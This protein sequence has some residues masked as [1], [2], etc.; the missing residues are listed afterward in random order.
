MDQTPPPPVGVAPPVPPQPPP[1]PPHGPPSHSPPPPP[2][3]PGGG[4]RRVGDAQR[5]GERRTRMPGWH[6]GDVVRATF[7]VGLL[8]V[9]AKLLWFSQQLLLTA[10][11]G[12]LFGLA[13]TAAVD[14]M[15]KF[16]IPRGIAAAIV[17]LG[18]L[19]LL[20]GFGAILA[21]TLKTQSREL[22]NRLPE[23][24]DKLDTW[25]AK[26]QGGLLGL[27]LPRGD[28]TTATAAAP[29]APSR[30]GDT[31]A[32]RDT[33]RRQGDTAAAGRA[34]FDSA[35][36]GSVPGPLD[37]AR[38]AGSRLRGQILGQ[39]SGAKRYFFP[40]LTSTL[41]VLG[42]IVLV[43]FLAI[44]VATDPDTYHDG[45][46][47]LFPHRTRTRAG[48]VLT[49]MATALRKWLVTQLIAMLAI[50][51]VTTVALLVLKVKAAVS[52]GI[53]AGLLEFIPTIGPLLSAVPAVAMAFIDSPE[54][55]LS[56]IIAYVI[57]QFIENHL[58]IPILMKEGVDLPP[59]LTVMAQ[60]LMALVFGFL[61]LLVAVPLTAAIVVAVK[62]LYVQDV[63]GDD[64]DVLEEEEE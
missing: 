21:P 50:G 61:G 33:A 63:V 13:V 38:S 10:F 14:R 7:L 57:I 27:I 8:Y 41:A 4:K 23:A 40:F 43:L 29:P 5:P 49:A 45:L 3:P 35:Q 32:A 42:G 52:L 30:G 28:D 44:Y 51:T 24:L 64:I 26:R 15:E 9:L 34:A 36:Q 46:M 48:E 31:G 2:P 6:S 62:M 60:A 25:L 20:S 53:L 59:A 16:R 1:Q 17:V 54:K 19:G 55:A 58:L 11:L 47:H 56:V 12:I 39:M 22:R 18:T 37:E